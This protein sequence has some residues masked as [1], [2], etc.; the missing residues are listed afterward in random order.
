MKRLTLVL[1]L[2]LTALG[3]SAAPPQLNASVRNYRRANEQ[4]ILREFVALL[5]LPNVASDRE[6]IRRNAA[7]L[8][9]L[10]RARG[11][12]PRLL[13]ASGAGVPPVVYGEWK[14]P[15]ATQTVV[16][17]AHYDGQPTDPAKWTGTRP[18]E[19]TLR[20]APLEA[21]GKILPPPA[22]G[23]AIN[24][25]W[26]L[27]ARSA[28]DDKAGVLAILT[29][30][31]ALRAQGV[32]PTVNLKFFFEGEEEAGSPHLV[33]IMT[34]QRELLAADLWL[35]CDGP[36]HQSGRKQVVFGVRG[37]TNVDVTVYGAKRPL[38]SGHYGNWAPNPALLLA[39]LLA[40]MK[41]ASGRVTIQGWYDDVE[42]LGAA[43]RQ[44][45]AEAPAYDEQ[46]R[47]DLGLARTEGGAR[48]LL[49]LINEPSLNVN[50]LSSAETGALARNVIPTT[51]TAALD[52][53][54]VRGN[55]YRRQVERLVAHIRRQGFYVVERDPTD[56]ERLAHPLIARVTHRPG[57]YNAERTPM[58]LPVARGVV[59]A[60]QSAAAGPVVRLPTLGGSLPLA[61][62]RETLGAPTIT[63]P[64]ANYDNNQHAED[65]NIRLQNLWDG[66][67][68][69]AALMTMNTVEGRR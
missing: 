12:S 17:Y 5:A 32:E 14:T 67:E 13:E 64:I 4:R 11:L 62:I 38:H 35:I 42:P 52:L 54:L 20:D 25:E 51:A 15:G 36:V 43:E 58:D 63:V 19:P 16:F 1:L 55:D 10:M 68:I 53:R 8:F 29:A 66:I 61:L 2:S 3:S 46:L 50:G 56:A 37:D 7:H 27:Y 40:S 21:G 39:R 24:P 26:R 9:E 49:E 22:E 47:R 57:G 41:D 30:F 45:L 69:M 44:A 18:W 34:R 33:E 65:E 60:V 28:S 48:T 59:A 23:E 6:N 31:D